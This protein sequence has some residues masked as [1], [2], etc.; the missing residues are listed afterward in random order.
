MK[1]RVRL[2]QSLMQEIHTDL[3]RPHPF[4]YERVGFLTCGAAYAGDDLLLVGHRWHVVA[5]DDYVDDPGAGATIGGA[6]FRRIFE[7]IYREPQ[8]LLH[9]HMHDHGGR[10]HF[11]HTDEESMREFVPGFFN[12]CRAYPHGALVLSHNSGAG[13]IWLDADSAP[14][15]I[16]RIDVIG[17]PLLRWVSP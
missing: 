16:E 15:E 1:I 7:L 8:A 9:I 2:L 5:D 4:A 11:S 13:S 6:A 3:A 17:V 14:R 12:A 10:P